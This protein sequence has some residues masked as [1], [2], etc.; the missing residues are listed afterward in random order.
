MRKLHY[1]LTLFTSAIF[2]L[3]SCEKNPDEPDD[4]IDNVFNISMS[5]NALDYVNR[6][7]GKYFIYKVTGI[8]LLDSVVV[9]SNELDTVHLPRDN[10]NN[11]PEHNIERLRLRMTKY[12]VVSGGTI[13][14]DWMKATALPNYFIPF[15]STTTADVDLRITGTTQTIFYARHN[16]TGTTTMTVEGVTYNGVVKAE[17]DNGL[18]I[19]DPAYEKNTFYWV[20]GL[21]VIKRVMVTF[22]GATTE[23][24]LLRH[25]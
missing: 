13:S 15:D 10:N 25:N 14:S 5:R 17:S 2:F 1:L 6:P 16:V 19:T 7:V 9:T 22:N 8:L 11:F 12:N 23:S 24:N 4:P 18:P 20:K 21:G 3:T